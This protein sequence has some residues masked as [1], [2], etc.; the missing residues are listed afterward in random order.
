MPNKVHTVFCEVGVFKCKHEHTTSKEKFI[1]CPNPTFVESFL[2]D[3]IGF[4]GHINDGYLLCFRCYKYF[5]SLLKPDIC[6][7]SYET[8]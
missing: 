7:L 4:Q 2:R 8:Y 1:P 5:N 6:T 3:T